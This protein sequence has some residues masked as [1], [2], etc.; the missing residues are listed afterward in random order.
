MPPL[1]WKLSI[2]HQEAWA[3]VVMTEGPEREAVRNY[4]PRGKPT[5]FLMIVIKSHSQLYGNI[6]K[7]WCWTWFLMKKGLMWHSKT[8]LNSL[9]TLGAVLTH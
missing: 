7:K 5:S 3:S 6:S 8:A 2:R 9:L 4:F 1:T